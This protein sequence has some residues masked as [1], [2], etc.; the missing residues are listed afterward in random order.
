MTAPWY[1]QKNITEIA[2]S[3]RTALGFGTAAD[4]D[5][6]DFATPDD[7]SALETSVNDAIAAIEEDVAAISGASDP[8]ALQPVGALI[9]LDMGEGVTPPPT[10]QTY[11]YIELT[12]GLSGAGGYN[13]GV[14]TSETVSGS[15]PS[16]SATA[17]VALSGSPLNGL[18]IHLINTERRFIRP[19]SPGTLEDGQNL[20]HTHT[21]S[22]DSAGAHSVTIA[23]A[24]GSGSG[25]TSYSTQQS[26]N[27]PST[28]VIASI[29]NHS[30]A[31]T[32]AA[33]GG[34]ESRPRNIG[35]KY[36]R[37]IK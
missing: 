3:L 31:L 8:W 2:A 28:P 17:V 15:A 22:T 37:R 12:A 14:L 35:V 5:V 21:G 27:A 16:I 19:G 11:R 7:L 29:P 24:S 36:Y 30:H 1:R 6:E 32:I 9:A 25:A 23:T 4:Q 33:R 18:T 26:Y 10:D 34:S 20:S 13:N